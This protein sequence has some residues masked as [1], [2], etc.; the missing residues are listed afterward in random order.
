MRSVMGLDHFANGRRHQL[1]LANT[2]HV[3]QPALHFSWRG[4]FWFQLNT[5]S[6][7]GRIYAHKV[8]A[9]QVDLAHN[10]YVTPEMLYL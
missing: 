4:F 7:Y 10:S 8:K 3:E 2:L 6:Q 9:V 1:I 5:C